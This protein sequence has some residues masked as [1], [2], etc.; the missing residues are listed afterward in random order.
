MKGM[1]NLWILHERK[2]DKI[3]KNLHDKL[4]ILFK[5]DYFINSMFVM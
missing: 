2:A 1:V 5:L 3:P 4:W